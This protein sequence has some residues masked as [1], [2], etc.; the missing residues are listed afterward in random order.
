MG[1]ADG[2][3]EGSVEDARVIRVQRQIARPCFLAAEKYP[4]PDFAA[5]VGA[6]D[7]TFGIGA[8]RVTLGREIDQVGILGMNAYLA[9][10]AR[11]LKA[12][13]LPGLAAIGR[14][15]DAITVR[16]VAANRRLAHSH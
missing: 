1:Q 13:K 12:K 7:A 6:I 8:V 5:V 15:V 3:P 9:N 4:L 14:F 2:F 10:V 11:I 16:N